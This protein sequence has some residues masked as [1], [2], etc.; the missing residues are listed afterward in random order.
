MLLTL[1]E[2]ETSHGHSVPTPGVARV[3]AVTGVLAKR[4]CG[5]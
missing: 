4:V 1:V 3:K 2:V 5:T